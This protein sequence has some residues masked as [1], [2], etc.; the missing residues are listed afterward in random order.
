MIGGMDRIDSNAKKSICEGCMKGKQHRLPY[1]KSSLSFT[2]DNLEIIHTD[3]C[4]P[5]NIDSIGG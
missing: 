1:P 5:M 3:I 4:G 2:T